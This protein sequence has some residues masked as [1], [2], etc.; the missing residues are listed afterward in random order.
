MTVNNGQ[1]MIGVGSDKDKLSIS[2]SCS[3][4]GVSGKKDLGGSDFA[5]LFSPGCF[6]A[7]GVDQ[8]A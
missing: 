5:E 7:R 3:R 8:M 1:K 2:P 4:R 6:R